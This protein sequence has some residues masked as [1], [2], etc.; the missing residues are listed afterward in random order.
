MRQCIIFEG[1]RGILSPMA[2]KASA[3][4]VPLIFGVVGVVAL[5][6]GLWSPSRG[7]VWK[8][9][10]ANNV[11]SAGVSSFGVCDPFLSISTVK[12]DPIYA[13]TPG[14]VVAAGDGFVHIASSAEP[15]ILAYT[16]VVPSVKVGES[17]GLGSQIALSSGQI[18]F[19]V[20]QFSAK[21]TSSYV[22][23]QAWLASR[24]LASVHDL[25][26]SGNARS[27]TV[28]KAAVDA[29]QFALPTPPGFTLLPVSVNQV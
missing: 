20:T 21:N 12:G 15:V 10:A 27:V 18:G 13:M 11:Q 24:G 29:C 5:V 1:V 23:P 16:G 22:D 7:V 8:G 9:T 17:V 3:V 6:R 14:K 19:G 28:K 25:W 4:A 2:V 26:G